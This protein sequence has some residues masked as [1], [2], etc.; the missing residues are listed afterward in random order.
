MRIYAIDVGFEMNVNIKH[1]FELD[2]QFKTIPILSYKVKA[3]GIEINSEQTSELVEEL[4]QIKQNVF[5][6]RYNFCV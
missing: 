6:V 1:C 5:E 3:V 4:K 2:E